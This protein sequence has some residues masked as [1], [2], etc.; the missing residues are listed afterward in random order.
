MSANL[1]LRYPFRAQVSVSRDLNSRKRILEIQ[2]NP[3]RELDDR[4]HISL[5][6]TDF[7]ILG[8]KIL[9]QKVHKVIS[10]LIR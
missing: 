1:G 8:G 2:V 6:L 10:Q 9:H 4:D 7:M 3:E 5:T